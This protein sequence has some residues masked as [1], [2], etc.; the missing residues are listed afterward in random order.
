M[1]AGWEHVAGWIIEGAI[2][3]FGLVFFLTSVFERER[4]AAALSLMFTVLAAALWAG[5]ML[6]TGPY[7]QYIVGG[8]AAAGVL[9]FI[10]VIVPLGRSEPLTPTGE[11]GRV[12]ERDVIFARAK[13]KPEDYDTY[14]SAHPG[15]K[16]IDDEIRALPEL[17]EPGGRYY[18]RENAE[19]VNTM[20]AYL[21]D[22]GPLVDGEVARQK[23]EMSPEDAAARVKSYAEFL[24]AEL[25]GIASLN[26]AYVYSHVGRGSGKFGEK[27]N[28]NHKYAVVVAVE[29]RRPFVRQAPAMPVS[30][31]SCRGYVEC[32]RIAQL[33]A[34]YIRALG[35]P[36]RA[37]I[38]ANY[39]VMCVPIAADAG[40]GELSR[41][42]YLITAKYGPRVRLSVVTT[43]LTVAADSPVN[44]GVRDF[45]RKCKKCARNCPAQAIPHRNKLTEVRG[46]R[47]WEIDREACYRFW[48]RIGTDCGICMS[49]CTFSKP[50]SLVHNI[51]RFLI[52]RSALAR[53]V[54]I[55]GDDIMY[56]RRP[57]SAKP[58]GWMKAGS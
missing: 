54:A 22:I 39:R 23:V 17:G 57:R 15:Y 42:G 7:L 53:W 33:L 25:V 26:P 56:G 11:Q 58:P 13:I 34:R 46:I 21:E 37:H 45:C 55:I 38:D 9:G 6:L 35:Y 10:N 43:N 24:G 1:P 52:R 18:D 27:I 32:A 2:V 12:D 19:I 41:M 3:F 30:V 31:E 20:F 47:K 4:R 48:R 49:V 8:V 16:D 40:L 51:V 29:M 44:L 36:A 14:Y 28:L 50:A 5:V